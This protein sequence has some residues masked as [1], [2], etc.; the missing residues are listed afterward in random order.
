MKPAHR[1]LAPLCLLV[2]S[3]AS[4]AS[5][6]PAPNAAPPADNSWSV[7][8]APAPAP[9]APAP[10]PAAPAPAPAAGTGTA[11]PGTSSPAPGT[12]IAAP[13]TA[14][15][16]AGAKAKPKHDDYDGPP[17]LLG[18]KSHIGGYGGVIIAYSH[19]LREDGVLIG[20]EGAVLANHRLSLGGAGYGFSRT[21]SGPPTLTGE[22][23]E[24]ITGY[25]GLVLRY[26]VF[27]DNVPVYAS[28]GVLLGGGAVVLARDHCDECDYDD[29][30][31]DNHEEGHGY[32]VVQPDLSLHVNATRW[33]RFGLT[34]GYRFATAVDEYNFQSDEL[35]GVVL[36]GTIQAG[37]F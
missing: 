9:A 22:R 5:A 35:G 31:D 36:G 16:A 19:M 32:F 3:L 2:P 15:P 14:A 37:W 34:A 11:T 24:F 23:R 26:A 27:A 8:P 25:G 12:G 30:W 6:Q 13:G 29:D 28:L 20:G 10:A 4:V 21:P 33:L 17:L 7:A 1:L 18:K